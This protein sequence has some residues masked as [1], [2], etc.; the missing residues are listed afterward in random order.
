MVYENISIYLGC[1]NIEVGVENI[2]YLDIV[3]EIGVLF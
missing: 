1:E 3:Y 2:V